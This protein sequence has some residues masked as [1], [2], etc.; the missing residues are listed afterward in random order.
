MIKKD[1]SD[2]VSSNIG[3]V[4]SPRDIT[5]SL[6]L[7]DGKRVNNFLQSDFSH[8]KKEIPYKNTSSSI[9]KSLEKINQ[10]LNFKRFE[11]TGPKVPE[12]HART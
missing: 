7:N 6:V 12:T 9:N 4:A 2:K 8:S 10:A 3:R 1:S 11:E 5:A